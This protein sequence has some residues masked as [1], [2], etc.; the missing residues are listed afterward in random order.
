M[1]LYYFLYVLLCESKD[2]QGKGIMQYKAKLI[3]GLF[4]TDQ[5][6]PTRASSVDGTLNGER[7][8]LMMVIIRFAGDTEFNER[9]GIKGYQIMSRPDDKGIMSLRTNLYEDIALR[10]FS[11]DG[12]HDGCNRECSCHTIQK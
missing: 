11:F 4:E 1:V 5:A 6:L 8:T 7:V 9:V 3:Q 12:F 2:K 10:V